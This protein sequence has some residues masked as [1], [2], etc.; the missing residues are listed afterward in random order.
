[1]PNYLPPI[2]R[3]KPVYPFSITLRGRGRARA[4]QVRFHPTH[5]RPIL[6]SLGLLR[7]A[8][9]S[10]A[11]FVPPP[12]NFLSFS[13]LLP[14]HVESREPP[15]SAIFVLSW[16]DSAG[17]ASGDRAASSFF[18]QTLVAGLRIPVFPKD[19]LTSP[20]PKSR[21]RALHNSR[22]CFRSAP[23]RP[24]SVLFYSASFSLPPS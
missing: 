5:P 15:V 10:V 19:S 4:Q 1:M 22:V 2:P 13:C 3:S 12:V 18:V 11:S 8:L 7:P 21:K 16:R 24:V 20:L 17:L 9:I 14:H 6:P 23:A